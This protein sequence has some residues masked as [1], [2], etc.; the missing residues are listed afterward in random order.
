MLNNKVYIANITYKTNILP[1]DSYESLDDYF[2]YSNINFIGRLSY[3]KNN[4]SY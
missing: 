3:G 1:S 4:N 2:F